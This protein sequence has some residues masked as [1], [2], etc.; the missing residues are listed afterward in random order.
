MIHC[1]SSCSCML[2][3]S[4]SL[5]A[6]ERL[7]Q[8][9]FRS[10]NSASLWSLK[11]IHAMCEME[12]SR[13]RS[14][15][16]SPPIWHLL[17]CLLSSSSSLLFLMLWPYPI[18]K[19]SAEIKNTFLCALPHLKLIHFMWICLKAGHV[20]KNSFPCLIQIRSQAQFQDLCQQH[21]RGETE[22][23]PKGGCCPSWSLGNYLAVLANASCCLSLTS[24]QVLYLSSHFKNYKQI[25][26]EVEITNTRFF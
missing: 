24:H 9:V 22:G 23:T 20:F 12:Q 15:L 1:W 17:F 8:L 21:V 6:G 19:C 7:A 4:V 16:F 11:A 14:D 10:E 2:N 18:F 3:P 13:V 5:H 26:T 25:T